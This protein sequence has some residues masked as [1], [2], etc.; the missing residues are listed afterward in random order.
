MA[1]SSKK[2]QHRGTAM[3]YSAYQMHS[4]MMEPIR[5]AARA[6]AAALHH[7][8]FRIHVRNVTAALPSSLRAPN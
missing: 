6:S 7:W 5:A 2:D 3:M 1:A 8:V 4:D